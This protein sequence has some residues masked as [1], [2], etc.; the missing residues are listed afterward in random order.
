MSTGKSLRDV[1][2]GPLPVVF[3]VIAN[4]YVPVS[5]TRLCLS[6]MRLIHV[7]YRMSS[8]RTTFVVLQYYHG[9]PLCRIAVLVPS[10]W[11]LKWC[12]TSQYEG[13]GH[14]KCYPFAKVWFMCSNKRIPF[15]FSCIAAVGK[16]ASSNKIWKFQATQECLFDEME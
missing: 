5:E 3:D 6:V 12:Q 2:A 7:R 13:A 9:T 11:C 8:C 16:L 15:R 1:I 10:T 4:D 14:K